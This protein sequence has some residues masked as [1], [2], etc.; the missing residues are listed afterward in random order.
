MIWKKNIKQ[1]KIKG[2]TLIQTM[3][4]RRK[5]LKAKLKNQQKK[6]KVKLKK[7]RK[8]ELDKSQKQ[9]IM[10]KLMKTNSSK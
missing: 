5:R 3:I 2:T 7:Q 1:K 6:I 9:W 10:N 8:K 4:K